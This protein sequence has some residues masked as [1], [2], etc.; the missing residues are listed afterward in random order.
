M[1]SHGRLLITNDN[2][3][4]PPPGVTDISA[5]AQLA[6]S[7]DISVA[8]TIYLHG[9][10]DGSVAIAALGGSSLL[11]GEVT[12]SGSPYTYL[13][14][15]SGAKVTF[16]GKVGG[17]GDSGSATFTKLGAGTL[18]FTNA[19]SGLWGTIV[20]DAHEGTILVGT[21]APLVAD[22]TQLQTTGGSFALY[23]GVTLAFPLTIAG[24]GAAGAGALQSVGGDTTYSGPITLAGDAGIGASAS[25]LTVS[26]IA[27][28]AYALRKS[29][30]G[31]LIVA[32]TPAYAGPID[33]MGGTLRV[34]G[35]L[36]A[37]SVAS[38]GSGSCPERHRHGRSR[39]RAERRPLLA[40][41]QPRPA[42]RRRSDAGERGDL[43]RGDERHHPRH[44]V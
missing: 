3:L 41:A 17:G 26:D 25:T 18:E 38:V 44:A 16:A 31:T 32:G 4:G 42:H 6:L 35:T 14:A 19:G 33:V 40:R 9:T 12:R 11:T 27:N 10:T 7:G 34:D 24:Y 37:A 23:N 28:S 15:A 21:A 30:P 2:A 1:L 36:P 8:E 39:E 43:L 22:T 13:S 20:F 29:G 5:G